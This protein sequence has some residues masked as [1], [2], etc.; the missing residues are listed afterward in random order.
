[1]H[2]WMLT[3]GMSKM[4]IVE[5]SAPAHRQEVVAYENIIR[6]QLDIIYNTEV[7]KCLL[8]LLNPQKKIWILPNPKLSSTAMTFPCK[9]VKEGGGIR[10]HFNPENWVGT[11]DDTL[12]HELT[13]ALRFSYNR[14]YRKN[15][16]HDSYPDSEEFLATQISNVYRS[17]RGKSQLYGAYHYSEGYWSSKGSIYQAFVESPELIM[18]LKFCLDYEELVSRIARLKHLEFNPFNDYPVLERMALSKVG[19]GKFMPL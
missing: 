12:V 11:E 17:S 13:H 15:I 10:I 1:M 3:T 19:G 6:K 14:F 18:A 8:N 2:D 16:L 9:T 4:E 7:G 5:D